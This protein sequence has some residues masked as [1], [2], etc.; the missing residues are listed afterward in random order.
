MLKRKKNPGETRRRLL[1]TATHLFAKH[2]YHGVS[3]DAI[4]TATKVNKRMVYHYFGSKEN[5]YRECILT[6][7]LRLEKQEHE[8]MDKPGN[9]EEVLK[10]VI[11]KYFAFHSSNPEFVRLLLWEN[12]NNGRAIKKVRKFLSKHP[13]L[14][15]LQKVVEEGVE[16]GV[17]REDIDVKQL[18]I[19]IIG[20]SFIYHSN[21]HTLSQALSLDLSSEKVQEAGRDAAINLVLNGIRTRPDSGKRARKK[22]S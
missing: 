3:V 10:E 13:A 4:V 22:K 6:V 16:K 12:L 15:G 11:K 8:V 19:N 17:F 21:R 1:E 9:P 2:G 14:A 20:L 7:Y 18:L 5:L